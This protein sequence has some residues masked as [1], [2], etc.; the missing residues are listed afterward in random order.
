MCFQRV[1][2]TKWLLTIAAPKPMLSCLVWC[3]PSV[4]GYRSSVTSSSSSASS[5]RSR[6]T[7]PKTKTT[8]TGGDPTSLP[9]KSLWLGEV[10]TAVKLAN[11]VLSFTS[12]LWGRVPPT[13]LGISCC[14]QVR[15]GKT[16]YWLHVAKSNVSTDVTLCEMF[17]SSS[18]GIKFKIWTALSQP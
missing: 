8:T 1:S 10:D 14:V 11:P 2:N 5:W 15:F 7:L 17:F 9:H 16:R 3:Q 18:W 13:H 6:S 4:D 12:R